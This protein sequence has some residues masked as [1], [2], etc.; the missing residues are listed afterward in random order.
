MSWGNLSVFGSDGSDRSELPANRI[1]EWFSVRPARDSQLGNKLTPDHTLRPVRLSRWFRN[2]RSASWPPHHCWAATSS[3]ARSPPSIPARCAGPPLR[4]RPAAPMVPTPAL[5][6]LAAEP[7]LRAHL[8]P[9]FLA[10][11]LPGAPE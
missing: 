8:L 4:A 10:P 1:L 3:P 9:G 7:L 11:T 5:R 2:P 6:G